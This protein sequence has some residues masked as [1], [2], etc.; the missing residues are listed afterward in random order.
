MKGG[1]AVMV[2]LGC[3]ATGLAQVNYSKLQEHPRS[4]TQFAEA[5]K[6]SKVGLVAAIQAA[7]KSGGGKA[8]VASLDLVDGKLSISVEVVAPGSH[9]RVQVDPETGKVTKTTDL[10]A[11]ASTG[12][13]ARILPG[14]AVTGEPKKTESG[15]MYYDLKVG[16]GDAPE[17][18]SKV[19]VHY[20][21]WLVTGKKFDS[22]VDRGKPIDFPL[23]GVIKGWTEG[24]G[25]MKVGGKRKL[26]IPYSLAYKE[27]G[28]PPVIPPK[29][30]LI[31]DV[32]LLDIVSK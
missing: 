26:I 25:S 17:P 16:E 30:M 13:P 28:R 19:K 3:L 27:Q 2:V 11:Q 4:S 29:A 12:G 15:L 8:A 31:F 20:T 6:G 5:V 7:E 23:N 9:K 32:E 14:D 1:L 18:T 21:G 22:S 10:P 24:V